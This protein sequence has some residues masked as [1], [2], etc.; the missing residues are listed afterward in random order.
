MLYSS[1]MD[2]VN[3]IP[4]ILE[5]RK[6]FFFLIPAERGHSDSFV[7]VTRKKRQSLVEYAL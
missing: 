2:V 5:S 6:K 4:F 1:E 7:P 3:I